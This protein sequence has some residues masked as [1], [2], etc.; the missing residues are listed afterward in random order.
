[1][2]ATT[3]ILG[4]HFLNGDAARAV[5]HVSRTGGLLV[6]PAAPALVRLQ[7]DDIYRTAI[8]SADYA[9]PDSGLM[10]LTWKVLQRESVSRV[11]GLAYLRSLVRRPEFKE[12]GR[13]FYVLPTQ[14]SG[15]K[16]LTWAVANDLR[17]TAAHCYVAPHYQ[18]AVEDPELLALLERKQPQQI[19][20]AIGNGPQEKLGVYLREHLTYRPAI[21]CIGAALGFLT[22]D[23]VAIPDWAD[24]FYLG[25]LLRL[26]AQPRIFIPRLTRAAMLPWLIFRYREALPPIIEK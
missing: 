16:L 17:I 9:I 21:H 13:T 18:L 1:M 24:R 20:I 10:V 7:H 6:V 5:E 22:G 25:W 8:T 19:I 12:E 26:F 14:D 15:D 4:I 23:Q 11:S 3:Q 2:S